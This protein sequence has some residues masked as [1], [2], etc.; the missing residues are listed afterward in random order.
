MCKSQW[1]P[2]GEKC[3]AIGLQRTA[4]FKTPSLDG[5]RGGRLKVEDEDEETEEGE[6]ED[7]SLETEDS[8][9]SS[10]SEESEHVV[11]V[12]PV[13]NDEDKG[14]EDLKEEGEWL[15][16]KPNGPVNALQ[17]GVA[18]STVKPGVPAEESTVTV[19]THEGVDQNLTQ[20]FKRSDGVMPISDTNVTSVIN[21]TRLMS[22]AEGP[23][24]AD[25]PA[26]AFSALKGEPPHRKEPL[27]EALDSTSNQRPRLHKNLKPKLHKEMNT[28][29]LVFKGER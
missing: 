21:R 14:L 17:D 2:R 20:R 8:D 9:S 6:E 23:S 16:G 10:S 25:I 26:T 24:D 1:T 27:R 29:F 4:R 11:S 22:S 5:K 15:D 7:E 13:D 19:D 18:S 12:A 28:T 3:Y